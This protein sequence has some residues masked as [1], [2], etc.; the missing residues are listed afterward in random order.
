MLVNLLLESLTPTQWK[1]NYQLKLL[2]LYQT[3]HFTKCC[4]LRRLTNSRSGES[5]ETNGKDWVFCFEK[6]VVNKT[7]NVI[8]KKRKGLI[9][10]CT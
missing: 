3:C 5:K 6:E 4:P 2:C 9:S 8:N 10:K 1:S 7:M